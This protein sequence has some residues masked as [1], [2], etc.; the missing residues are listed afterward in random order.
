MSG[1]EDFFLRETF[2]LIDALDEV[3]DPFEAQTRIF[4]HIQ[5]VGFTS[6]TITRLPRPSDRLGPNMLFNM[7]PKDWLTHYDRVGHYRF[8]PVVRQCYRTTEPFAWSE[9]PFDADQPD[10]ARRVMDE[11]AAFGLGFGFCIPVHDALGFQGGVS[12][13]GE[14]IDL[15]PK[16]RRGL[17]MLGL[18]AWGAATR[19][20]EDRRRSEPGRLLS[21]RERDVL[22]WAA[23]GRT[24]EEIATILGVSHETVAT[25]LKSARIKIGARNTTQTVVEALRKREIT[26]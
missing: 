12:L 23:M 17:H 16:I 6:F 21:A 25:H 9:V 2:A 24:R 15:S 5:H 19:T 22:S 8:D 11:A 7:W 13:A 4:E 20:T 10:R 3:R 18:Y 1:M 26:L 14:R